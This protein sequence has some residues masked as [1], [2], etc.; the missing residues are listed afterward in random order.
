[1]TN[2]SDVFQSTY[3]IQNKVD[4]RA[5]VDNFSIEWCDRERMVKTKGLGREQLW[6]IGIRVEK[7]EEN[8]EKYQNSQRSIED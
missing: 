2:V 6:H 8:N 4:S 1:M 5:F 7:Q 3:C